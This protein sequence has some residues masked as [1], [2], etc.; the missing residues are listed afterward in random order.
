MA[1]VVVEGRIA[2]AIPIRDLPSDIRRRELEG[3]TIAAG[4]VDTQVNG[5]G[6]ALFNETPDVETLRVIAGAH[7]RFGTTGFLPTVIS[8]EPAVVNR[9]MRAVERAIAEGVPGILGIHIEGP[10]LAPTRHGIHDPRF[11]RGGDREILDLIRSLEIGRTLVTVAPEVVGVEAIAELAEAGIVVSAGHTEATYDEMRAGISAGISGVTHLFNAMSAL[12]NRAPGAVGAAL[13]NPDVWCGIIVDGIHV[14]PATL[15][16][17][18]RCRPVD[19]F[20]LVTDAMTPAGTDMTS[21]D[22]QGRNIHVSGD[23]CVDS[24]GTLAGSNLT[25]AL[26]MRNVVDLLQLPLVTAL[27][28]ASASPSAFLRLSGARG[29]IA[30]GMTADLV[31]LDENHKVGATWIDGTEFQ[32]GER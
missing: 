27:T 19:R 7:R 15:R 10:M 26:A 30:P 3:G 1:V 9:A 22:L 11:I 32:D 5:G 12:T 23:R 18:L 14:H 8:D 13:E 24:Q 2:S 21:F 28:L 6:G 17:A 4:F 16:L 20:M 25:M 29:R 31:W